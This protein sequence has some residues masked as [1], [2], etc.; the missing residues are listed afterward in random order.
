VKFTCKGKNRLVFAPCDT[1]LKDIVFDINTTNE[2]LFAAILY[3]TEITTLF[4]VS[5]GYGF[6]VKTL[7]KSRSTS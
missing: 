2:P 4:L 5:F 3:K 6:C 1:M 7:D